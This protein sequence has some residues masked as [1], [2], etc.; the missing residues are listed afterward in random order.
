[1][2]EH[3]GAVSYARPAKNG[4]PVPTWRSR[5]RARQPDSVNVRSGR[6][7]CCNRAPS[8]RSTEKWRF[9]PS[10]K[11]HFPAWF[12]RAAVWV[13]LCR[14]RPGDHISPKR[15]R[16]FRFPSL[17]LRASM[18]TLL[19]AIER[20][21]FSATF[22]SVFPVFFQRA[23]RNGANLARMRPRETRAAPVGLPCTASMLKILAVD[24]FHTRI[25]LRRNNRQLTTDTSR[26]I[27]L[28]RPRFW[29]IG[30]VI[31]SLPGA[32]TR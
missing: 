3:A 21:P 27:L 12:N 32:S 4:A 14:S 31:L 5:R 29:T 7:A 11:R 25:R 22:S 20:G 10:K 16:G 1:M 13:T 19:P 28:I 26:R 2:G 23:F 9:G 18:P 30:V 8:A 24:V 6:R 17:A 15:K